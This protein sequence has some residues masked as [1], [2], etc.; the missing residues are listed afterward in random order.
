MSDGCAES[1]VMPDRS[2]EYD[3]VTNASDG[4]GDITDESASTEGSTES[5]DITDVSAVT[6]AGSGKITDK[7]A[8]FGDMHH[9]SASTE[10]RFESGDSTDHSDESDDITDRSASNE[11]SAESDI[12]NPSAESGDMATR[13]ARS[14][15]MDLNMA[16]TSVERGDVS[17]SVTR[18]K[19]NN[20]PNKK[21]LMASDT[22]PKDD[23]TFQLC[24]ELVNDIV[25]EAGLR[26]NFLS[27]VK[28]LKA[29]LDH[30]IVS[31]RT[32][33]QVVKTEVS[34]QPGLRLRPLSIL[35]TPPPDK[36]ETSA[37]S[38]T[39]NIEGFSSGILDTGFYSGSTTETKYLQANVVPCFGL[40][41]KSLH[42]H[43][44]KPVRVMPNA[45]QAGFPLQYHDLPVGGLNNCF[46]SQLM[47]VKKE[48]GERAV[49]PPRQDVRL[50]LLEE[51]IKGQYNCWDLCTTAK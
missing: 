18:E 30:R 45:V 48:E 37:A 11:G 3:G 16:L 21:D 17:A 24:S 23:E 13:N 22:M 4:S 27:A 39:E 10:G 35:T 42:S 36:D 12:T 25:T 34:A 44:I 40:D 38:A 8:E 26:A 1:G 47:P 41:L 46:G 9:K 15:Q 7:N 28:L 43:D 6:N 14:D 19:N 5:G 20:N 29:G 32:G 2:A 50:C 49:S 51:Q 31:L 33:G